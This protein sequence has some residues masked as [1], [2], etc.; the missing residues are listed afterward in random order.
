MTVNMFIWVDHPGANF[1][2][3]TACVRA[4]KTPGVT[5]LVLNKI[6]RG[7]GSMYQRTCFFSLTKYGSESRE[8]RYDLNKG[9]IKPLYFADDVIMS[10]Q[11]HI[12]FTRLCFSSV[13]YDGC[14]LLSND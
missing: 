9:G 8:I 13:V 3:R 14:G 11:I 4:E 5:F 7:A 1:D 10:G 12:N 6:R 2:I